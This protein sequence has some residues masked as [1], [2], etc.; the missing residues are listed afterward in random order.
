MEYTL[1]ILLYG[2]PT[3]SPA[4]PGKPRRYA[5]LCIWTKEVFC[6]SDQGKLESAIRNVVCE[7]GYSLGGLSDIPC[8]PLTIVFGAKQALNHNHPIVW[9]VGQAIASFRPS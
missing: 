4:I 9:I 7:R 1:T 3:Y 5:G 8:A 2:R 6:L